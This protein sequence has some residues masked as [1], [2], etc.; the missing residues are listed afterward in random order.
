MAFD[1]EGQ[2][3]DRDRKMAICARA[4]DLLT[5]KARFN[6][7]DIIFDVNILTVGTGIEEH[8]S[9]A[10]EF[11]EAVRGLKERLPL[12]KTSGGVSNVSFAFRGN[13]TVREAM[14]SA[15]LY[16]AISAGLDMGIVNPGQLE[17][18]EEIEPELRER[19]EDVLLNRR[20]DATERLTEFA[21]SVKAKSGKKAPVQ[22]LAW[23]ALPVEKRLEHA[24]VK[25]ITDYITEDTQEALAQLGRPLPVIE[26]PL[27][28]GMNT[29]GDLF[30]AGKMFLPQ[31]VKSARVMKQAV[32]YLTP[33]LEA[34]KAAA[35]AAGVDRKARGTVVMATVKGDVHDIGKN[36]VG[37]VLG[38]NDYRV[39]DL[40]VMV[41]CERILEAAVTE[42]ADM[43]GLSGLITPSL[44]EMVHVAREMDRQGFQLPL[45]IGG[46]TTSVKHT[47]VKIAPAYHGPVVHVKDASR[48]VG[49]VERLAGSSSRADFDRE[50]RELQERERIAFGRKVE[51]TL[52][53]YEEALARRFQ[54]EWTDAVIDEPAS[55]GTRV[56]EP[57]ID[58]LI[59]YIDWTPFFHAWELKGTFPRILDEP[60][61]G[62][63]ARRLM[64]DAERLLN[65][66]SQSGELVARGVYGFFPAAAERDDIILYTDASRSQE[67]E[68]LSMLRQQW[69][70][71]GQATFHSLADFIAPIDSG[72]PDWLGAFAVTAGIGCK[73]LVSQHK[74]RLDDYT[75]ILTE[76]L[77]DRLAEAFAELLHAR[78]RRDWGYGRNEHLSN[79]E[80]IAEKYRGIRPAPG[81]PSCPDHTEKAKLWNLLDAERAAE[82]MLTENYAMLPGASVSGWYFASPHARYFAVDLIARD[83]VVDY[84]KRK[85]IPLAEAERW[86]APIL[87]YEPV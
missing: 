28:D 16:H 48:A 21:E 72:R 14:N 20:P 66:L 82:I 7:R 6:P 23:R 22:D 37:V 17:V 86:L 34:E 46:A 80:M 52:V 1:E 43:I 13:D 24:L 84:A 19:V 61:I 39:V 33:F 77:A 83:Q 53:P 60:G 75:A 63:E 54:I 35:G 4:Y 45:L 62:P 40:G 87:A 58:D 67:R 32:A 79:E 44:E 50:N 71:H 36:I 51:R 78:A 56:V 27:M 8:A 68:R 9:Y 69:Q 11:I 38:C 57:S 73:E 25:G 85:G 18:Y 65:A 2:A 76:A 29:V 81:Y 15:F 30:G 47:A 59:P 10:V 70:R 26:G 41:P 31:V 5:R 49:T 64:G 55:L 42:G 3:V 74:A 12:T